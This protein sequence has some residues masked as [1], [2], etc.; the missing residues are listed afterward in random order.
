MPIYEYKC[1]E[2]NLSV[3]VIKPVSFNGKV[4]CKKCKK[5]MQRLISAPCPP[6]FGRG[7]PGSASEAEWGARRQAELTKRSK[8][9]DGSPAGK[10]EIEATKDRLKKQGTLP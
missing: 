5:G 10:Q 7:A 9:Y 8:D 6:R 4:P 2:C 3:E 1:E